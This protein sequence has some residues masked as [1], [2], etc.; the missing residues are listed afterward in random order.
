MLLPAAAAVAPGSSRRARL[1][2]RSG[3][4][5]GSPA[6]RAL[7]LLG[8]PSPRGTKGA[9]SGR[10][11]APPLPA[12]FCTFSA[13]ASLSFFS[14]LEAGRGGRSSLTLLPRSNCCCSADGCC[15]CERAL[16]R[17]S[18]SEPDAC[19]PVGRTSVVLPAC[20]IL[21]AEPKPA[22]SNKCRICV[23]CQP[24]QGQ[25]EGEQKTA[26]RQ[27][28]AE[29]AVEKAGRAVQNEVWRRINHDT[30]TRSRQHAVQAGPPGGPSLAGAPP[31]SS[32]R[33]SCCCSPRP[34]DMP[35]P[36]GS[37][38]RLLLSLV[39]RACPRASLPPAGFSAA[40]SPC[41]AWP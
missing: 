11:A 28:Q 23:D 31:R 3:T 39:R 35:M 22:K 33:R 30:T 32:R 9:A 41:S 26:A 8:R 7:P 12:S 15:N 34:E 20:F 14:S 4:P 16:S 29:E 17:R 24:A 10:K 21:S 37:P 19:S 25:Q 40:I 1:A 38:G 27:Q 5:A 2:S 18:R 6:A 36:G 13:A